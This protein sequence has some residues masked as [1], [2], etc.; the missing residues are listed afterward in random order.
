MSGVGCS[1]CSKKTVWC[2]HTHRHAHARMAKYSETYVAC[3]E[4][5]L[6]VGDLCAQIGAK[7]DVSITGVQTESKFKVYS[8]LLYAF[9]AYKHYSCIFSVSKVFVNENQRK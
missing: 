5:G 4:L 9:I 8:N 2:V 1:V 3:H 6:W 7:A